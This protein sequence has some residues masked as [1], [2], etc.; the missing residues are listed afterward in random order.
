M[1]GHFFIGIKIQSNSALPAHELKKSNEK[2]Q[3]LTKQDG[4]EII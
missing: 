1:Q 4:L 3:N 2:I